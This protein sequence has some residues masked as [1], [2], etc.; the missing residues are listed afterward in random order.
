MLR[1]CGS[2]CGTGSRKAGVRA[3]DGSG[4]G[5]GRQGGGDGARKAGRKARSSG[6]PVSPGRLR[7]T[8]SLRPDRDGRAR[9]HIKLEIGF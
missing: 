4:Y 2:N 6:Q 5:P 1:A 3:P 7:E 9:R 8:G